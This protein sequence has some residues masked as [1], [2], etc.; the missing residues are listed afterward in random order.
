M[1]FLCLG[2]YELVHFSGIPEYSHS[3]LTIDMYSD[4]INRLERVSR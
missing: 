1:R 2:F 3:I 4:V